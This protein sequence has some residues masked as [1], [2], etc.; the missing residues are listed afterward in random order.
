MIRPRDS[1]AH[2]LPLPQRWWIVLGDGAPVQLRL[3]E[4]AELERV[5]AGDEE[6]FALVAVDPAAP[7]RPIGMAYYLRGSIALAVA[8]MSVVVAGAWQRRGLGTVLVAAVA[9]VAA[10]SGVRAILVEVPAANL[11]VVRILRRFGAEISAGADE[12]VLDAH[13]NLQSNRNAFRDLLRAASA[14]RPV[15]I[16]PDPGWMG[17]ALSVMGESAEVGVEPGRAADGMG[18][19]CVDP[20]GSKDRRERAAARPPRGSAVTPP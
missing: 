12:R 14:D 16:R 19:G 13:V 18:A 5:E 11:P 1:L 8:E 6:R 15:G 20:P 17:P 10:Q 9:E 2:A 7:D 3:V 4:S